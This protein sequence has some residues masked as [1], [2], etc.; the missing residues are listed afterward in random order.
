MR[1]N[2]HDGRTVIV[3]G[4]SSGV[5][6][7][8]ALRF[9]QE[10]ANVVVADIQREPKQGE[11]FQTDVT[12][13]TDEVVGDELSGEAIFVETDV[14]D[15]A[16][17]EAMV[18]EAV[19]AFGGVDVL[20]NNA[21]IFIPGDSQEL[22]IEGWNEVLGVD[23]DGSFYSAK[24]AGPRLKASSGHLINIGSVH[25]SQGGGGPSYASA[26]GAILNLTRDL[27]VE[28]GEHAVNVNAICPGFVKTSVQDYQTDESMAREK[29]HTL[30]PYVADPEDIGDV[31]VFLASDEASFIHGQSIYV[32]GGWTAHRV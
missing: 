8:I 21:G 30:L 26:K 9:G 15:P 5:G 16:D 32:D 7:G 17:A 25:A 6:R 23:L 22:S 20:V 1:A 3:T 31:A 2:R 10:G 12:V 13:P 27:A 29:E 28:L 18:E 19:D 14:S 11:Y 4:G 24:Y